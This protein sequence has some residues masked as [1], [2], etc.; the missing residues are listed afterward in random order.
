[1]S[2]KFN[3]VV[4][5]LTLVDEVEGTKFTDWMAENYDKCIEVAK[6]MVSPSHYEDLYVD[7]WMGFKNREDNKGIRYNEETS[8]GKDGTPIKIQ[9][10][11]FGSMI[12]FYNIW[13]RSRHPCDYTII[14]IP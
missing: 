7:V 14:I 2:N 9:N 10:I 5:N 4:K 11:V 8:R 1:M 13:F 12:I 6:K 3:S